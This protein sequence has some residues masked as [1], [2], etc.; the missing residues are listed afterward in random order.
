M[1]VF[2]FFLAISGIIAAGIG[3]S[4]QQGEKFSALASALGIFLSLVS[5]LFWKLDQRVSEMIKISERAMLAIENLLGIHEVSI[6]TSEHQLVHPK[7]L[8]SIW[9][10]GK[11]FRITFSAVGTIGVLSIAI[12]YVI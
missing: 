9:T 10:Y 4:L 3:V 7:G 12:P 1:T 11:C 8:L 2:N 5:F 6:F